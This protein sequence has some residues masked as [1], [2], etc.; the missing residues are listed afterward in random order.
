L[1]QKAEH[2]AGKFRGIPLVEALECAAQ[3]AGAS[4]ENPE[5]GPEAVYQELVP[6]AAEYA[7]P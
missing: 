1:R 2:S 7:H 5:D 3:F 6:R 4:A